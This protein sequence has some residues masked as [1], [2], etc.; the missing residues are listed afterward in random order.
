MIPD[1]ERDG[2]E[3]QLCSI[4][5]Y[6]LYYLVK[7]EQPKTV[8]EVGTW[9]GGGSTYFISSALS[10]N[11]WGR[12]Y[13]CEAN[14]EFYNHAVKLYKTTLKELAPYVVFHFGESDSV[15]PEVLKKL[16]LVDMVMLD[17]AE[18]ADQTLKEYNMFLPYFKSGSFLIC[19]DWKEGKMAKLKPVI[20]DDDL[21][22]IVTLLEDTTTGFSIFKR[23]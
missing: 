22:E 13:T 5:R 23:K 8:F 17:G 10:E 20:L 12:L 6:I 15:Y 2:Q 11:Q 7:N 3:G 18:D 19:H 21:W 16:G 4:E 1:F 14:K 9:K